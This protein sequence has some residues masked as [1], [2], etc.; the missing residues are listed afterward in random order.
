MQ[1]WTERAAE[2]MASAIFVAACWGA[3]GGGAN[4]LSSRMGWKEAFRHIALGAIIAA[5]AGS[6][7]GELVAHW[8]MPS[9]MEFKTGA[10]VGV[11]SFLSGALGA[12]VL[13]RAR[14]IIGGKKEAEEDQAKDRP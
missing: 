3:L 1:R 2:A 4:V 9:G 11:A 13:E 14:G 6:L 12:S 8:V 5:G 10:S 7:V